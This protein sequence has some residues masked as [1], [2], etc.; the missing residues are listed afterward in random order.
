[1]CEGRSILVVVDHHLI[2]E[3]E[4]IQS[5]MTISSLCHK[6]LAREKIHLISPKHLKMRLLL[7]Y[8]IIVFDLRMTSEQNL[9]ILLTYLMALEEGNYFL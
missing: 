6:A 7:L 3:G 2:E 9:R 4:I 1:M 5:G 8:F